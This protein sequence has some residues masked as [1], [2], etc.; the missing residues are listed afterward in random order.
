MNRETF[1]EIYNNKLTPDQKEILPLFLGGLSNK[2]IAENHLYISS[3]AVSKR[4]KSIAERFNCPEMQD[5]RD[6]LCELFA[7][8]KPD[9][10]SPKIIEEY[11]IIKPHI[12]DRPEPLNSCFYI[13]REA[14]ESNLDTL[15]TESLIRITAP[16]KMGKTSLLK[17]IVA[18]CQFKNYHT[19]YLN[20]SQ[21]EDNRLQNESDFIYLFYN[22]MI[23]ELLDLSPSQ[24]WDQKLSA[25]TNCTKNFQGLLKKLKNTFVLVIDEVD[26]LLEYPH[27]YKN[28]FPLLRNWYERGN[29][30]PTWDKLKM[31]L[32]YSTEDYGRLDINQSPFNLGFPIKLKE[33]T[34]LQVQQLASRHRLN[35]EEILPLINLVGG[36]PFLIRLAFYHLF[37][38]NMTLDELISNAVTDSGI[39]R[40]H[41]MQLLRNLKANSALENAFKSVLNSPISLNSLSMT[42]PFYQ[43]E[44][45]GLITLDKQQ[46]MV[47]CELYQEY[48]KNRLG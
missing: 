39:Y 4:I 24:D 3:G 5:S 19:V 29:D 40:Q 41:L 27:I 15:I 45:M 9:L 14:F 8:Y 2:N 26:H 12:P 11:A 22:S 28:F 37:Y 17:R 38:Q 36:H 20:F 6:Y 42:I 47:R 43:L 1:F 25:M 7:Q 32:A 16:R 13:E 30:S 23:Q 18:H 31:I 35:S 48:F 44:S 33:F 34:P 10:V 21:I 46:A